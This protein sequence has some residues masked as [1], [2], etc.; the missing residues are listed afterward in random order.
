MITWSLMGGLLNMPTFSEYWG[1]FLKR[2]YLHI[3]GPHIQNDRALERREQKPPY[4]Y[5]D[6]APGLKMNSKEHQASFL[7]PE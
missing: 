2:P 6:A 4:P 5:G 1:H 3:Y 7:M